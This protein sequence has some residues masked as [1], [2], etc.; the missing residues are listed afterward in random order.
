MDLRKTFVVVICLSIGALHFII[1]PNYSGPFQWFIS[2]Y[3]IDILLP[4]CVYF[5]IALPRII[6]KPWMI[7]AIV[8]MIG[9][10]VET[11][12]YFGIYVFGSTFDIYDYLMYAIGALLAMFTDI[13]YFS[14]LKSN[15]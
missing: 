9:F 11:L 5:L 6:P 2:G 13:F 8:F 1:G 12:Q 4:F 14:K 15:E 10:T 7:A 3:L